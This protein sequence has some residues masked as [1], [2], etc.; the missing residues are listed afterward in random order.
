MKLIDHRN[1]P[2]T[3]MVKL[4]DKFRTKLFANLTANRLAEI[5]PNSASSFKYY[6][7]GASFIP[8]DLFKQLLTLHS[9]GDSEIN[10]SV[11]EIKKRLCGKPIKIKL[12]IC[13]SADLSELAG[14]T[15]GD[16]HISK[17]GRF[18][19]VNTSKELIER[20][21]HLTNKIFNNSIYRDYRKR[22]D[23]SISIHYPSALGELLHVCGCVKG[24][25]FKQDFDVPAWIKSGNHEVKSGFIRA[26]FDDEGT[27]SSTRIAIN[28][29]KSMELKWSLRKFFIS[30]IELLTCLNI[31]SGNVVVCAR[32]KNK[33]GTTAI[34][35]LFVI[36]GLEELRKFLDKIGFLHSAKQ[37]KLKTLVNSVIQPNY[38]DGEAREIILNSMTGLMSTK[39][40]SKI[41]KRGMVN[42]RYH[43]KL[44]EEEGK[45]KKVVIHKS[46]WLWQL[47]DKSE[48]QV[49]SP[50]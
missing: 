32:R 38:H 29:A 13:A 1:L 37:K 40:I 33:N 8:I 30:L 49:T 5:F 44:L 7:R 21:I 50:I 3:C 6:K 25:K 31:R 23:G 22:K 9:F 26:L 28:M 41:I 12:P 16:G 20:V 11:L 48:K 18:V 24:N 45:L 34:G 36:C 14:H 2:D 10:Q 43:L 19:Y 17:A 46:K 35:L 4:T 15:F 39:D 27:V 42:T 47:K